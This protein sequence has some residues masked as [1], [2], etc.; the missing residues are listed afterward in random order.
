MLNRLAAKDFLSL[1][2]QQRPNNKWVT[3]HSVNFH[4]HLIMTDCPLGK[5][6]QLQDF[7]VYQT[8]YR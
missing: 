4:L 1:L 8:K 7:I 2:K 5:P 3:E 6:P